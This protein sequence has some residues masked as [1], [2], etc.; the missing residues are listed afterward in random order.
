MFLQVLFIILGYDLWF[1]ASH[2]LL[3]KFFY[4]IHSLHHQIID[5][6]F[7]DEYTGHWIEGPVQGLGVFLP[8]LFMEFD[9]VAFI[10]A[11]I[12]INIRGMMR[13]D[14]RSNW[15]IGNHHLLH[16]KHPRY[17]YGEYWI[18]WLCGTR[19][20]K[21]NEYEYGLVYM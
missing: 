20:I 14:S 9:L 11:I 2:I 12:L 6:V 3:H 18:D 21:D 15:L 16:H 13:H 4:G 19:Y 10:I 1:Y 8:Y 17:N 5:P 7:T